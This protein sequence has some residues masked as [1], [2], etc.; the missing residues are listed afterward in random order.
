MNDL[1]DYLWGIVAAALLC[2]IACTLG[3]QNGLLKQ[4]MKL[5]TGMLIVLAVLHP[6]VNI[7]LDDL[8]GWSELI[9]SQGEAFVAQ[10]ADLG[11]QAYLDGITKRVEA[12]ILDEAGRLG[13]QVEVQVE[14]SDGELPLPVRV[15]VSGSLSPYAKGQLERLLTQDLGINREE[16]QWN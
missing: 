12:Y 10:G 5:M 4:V 3:P 13:A 2:G 15:A 6:W 14:L 7:S 16:I 9:T 1:R 11:T 8:F